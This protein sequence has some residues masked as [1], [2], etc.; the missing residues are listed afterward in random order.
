MDVGRSSTTCSP[1]RS[2]DG[3]RVTRRTVRSGL[4]G[5]RRADGTAASA[6]SPSARSSASRLRPPSRRSRSRNGAKRATRRVSRR[7]VSWSQ[8]R[9]PR[10]RQIRSSVWPWHSRGRVSIRRPAPRR[11]CGGRSTFPAFEGWSTPA[12]RSSRWMLTL[13]GRES[14]PSATTAWPASMTS[15]R[16]VDAGPVPSTE[17]RRRSRTMAGRCCWS[18]IRR[19]ASSTQQPAG[20]GRRRSGLRCPDRSTGSSRARTGHLW[21]RS[22]TSR[23]R[24][25]SRSRV[26]F[27]S[28][29]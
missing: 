11:R 20:K 26:V 10:S 17:R 3:R 6:C 19:Q 12:G 1:R 5:R 13:P 22:S 24:R 9:L 23:G 7:A 29:E 14:S 18:R 2:W 15:R 25:C 8:A 16:G 21:L 4:R 28:G 27:G